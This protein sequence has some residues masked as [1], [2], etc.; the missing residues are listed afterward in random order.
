MAGI[1]YVLILLPFLLLPLRPSVT[2]INKPNK[3][4][5]LY[6]GHRNK[7]VELIRKNHGCSWKYGHYIK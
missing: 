3:G 2:H 7:W 5:L 6:E 1:S 4:Y